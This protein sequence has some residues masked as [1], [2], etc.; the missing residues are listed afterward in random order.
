MNYKLIGRNDTFLPIE[1]VLNNRNISRK[2]FNLD[3]SVI[4]DYDNYD[5][6]QEGVE[7]LIQHLNNNNEI[8]IVIDSDVDGKTSFATLYRRIKLSYPNSNIKYQIHTGKQHGLSKDIIID[9]GI[10]LIILPDSSS[11]DFDE[12]KKLKEKGV[13]ILVIDHHLC[14]KGYSNNALVINN[15]L[16]KNVQNKN[17]SGVGVVYKFI[18]ALDDYLFEAKSNQF[19]DLVALGNIADV[20]DLREEETRYY[21]YKGL[22]EINNP[23]IKSLIEVNSYDLEGKY[24]IDKVGWVIA[25]K[26][27]GTI[28][29]GIQDEK[30]KMTQAFISDDYEFCLEVAKMCKSV[31]QRQD[32]AVKSSLTKI[33]KVLKIKKTDRC[34]ILNVE[35]LLN[36]NHT[37]LVAGKLADRYKMPTLLYRKDEEGNLSGSFRGVD[38]ISL[39]TRK[40]ILNSNLVIYSE[41]HEQAGGWSVKTN[42]ELNKLKEYLDDLYKDKEIIDNSNYEVDFIINEDEFDNYL[43]DELASIENEFG[44]GLMS[45]L[46]AFENMNVYI[47][48]GDIK[49]TKIIFNINGIDF[50]KKFPTNKLKEE[51]KNKELTMNIIGKCTLNTYS[52][53]GQVEIV[54][55]EIIN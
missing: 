18:K 1:T 12:H 37:G 51:L 20:M 50:I 24:N 55:F 47:S 15:Q 35:K 39:D 33:E 28:R 17:L 45:P 6:I 42:D 27:N 23:F 22:K 30:L 8:L 7:L 26:L 2:L 13:D 32:N 21:V 43:I 54:D 53:C 14:D 3:D 16:S 49:K 9:S 5:Y 4:E 38:N 48:D 36:K 11:N 31:K 19:M 40:D 41:G 44:N 29:S 34:I 52:N 25:P 10:K 46:I